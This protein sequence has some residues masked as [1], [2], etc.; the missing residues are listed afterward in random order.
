MVSKTWATVARVVM[1]M[2]EV[3]AV[4]RTKMTVTVAVTVV[5]IVI[6]MMV[7]MLPAVLLIEAAMATAGKAMVAME[8]MGTAVAMMI[9]EK[10][11]EGVRR[12]GL[13]MEKTMSTVA[14]IMMALAAMIVVKVVV[15]MALLAAG[16]MET[17]AGT[18]EMEAMM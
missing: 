9:E 4:T 10:M 8:T 13:T 3:A 6:V 18:I 14:T 17:A 7:V 2:A 11:V 5:A 16:R 12:V 15:L 1:V